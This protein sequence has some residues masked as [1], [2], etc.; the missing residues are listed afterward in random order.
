MAEPPP[1]STADSQVAA[2]RDLRSGAAPPDPAPYSGMPGAAALHQRRAVD[3][4]VF[5]LD[6]TVYLG[7]D[8][9]PG[10]V[11]AIATLRAR[12]KR[13]L[14]VSNKPLEQRHVYAAKLTRMG[15]P[16]TP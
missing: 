4:F 11:A 10:S 12:D 15:I 3:G 8:P 14:F 6:G 2:H 13:V 7:E 1:L 5:D 16:A 9:L